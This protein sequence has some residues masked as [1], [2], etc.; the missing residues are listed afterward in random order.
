MAENKRW[1]KYFKSDLKSSANFMS[2]NYYQRCT[3]LYLF[4]LCRDD[5]RFAGEFCWP[6]NG[7]PM[8]LDDIIED[9]V[10]QRG[11]RADRVK[12]AI[13]VLLKKGLVFYNERGALEIRN[14]KQKTTGTAVGNKD[15]APIVLCADK[16]KVEC[17]PFFELQPMHRAMLSRLILQSKKKSMLKR[18]A[19]ALIREVFTENEKFRW[20]VDAFEDAWSFGIP[21]LE[22]YNQNAEKEHAE[23][24]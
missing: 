2:M 21:T 23:S 3:Y 6:H 14:Y 20:P 1:V 9:M 17:S 15:I 13:G 22:I 7:S 16:K 5:D 4:L 19:E 24:I 12:V 8:N 18:K 11:D 10:L